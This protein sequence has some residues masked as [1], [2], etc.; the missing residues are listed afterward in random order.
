MLAEFLPVV[1]I[2]QTIMTDYFPSFFK[3]V[4]LVQMWHRKDMAVLVF[5]HGIFWDN[6]GVF[7]WFLGTP[8]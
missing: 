7:C 3:V 5:S 4:F 6:Y 8:G 1:F 2:L